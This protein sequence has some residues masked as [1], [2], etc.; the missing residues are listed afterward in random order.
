M[1]TARSP[2]RVIGNTSAGVAAAG[3][4]AATATPCP[5]DH[6][7]VTSGTLGQGVILAAGNPSQ[8]RSVGNNT[9]TAVSGV[10]I[11]VYPPSGAAF[12]GG[13][14]DAPLNLPPGMAAMFM[15]VTSLVI[16]CVT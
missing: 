11:L 12:N 7:S 16:N 14:A 10:S 2:E 15:F 9:G 8:I 5:A 6:I 13:T 1:P 4:T 3:T